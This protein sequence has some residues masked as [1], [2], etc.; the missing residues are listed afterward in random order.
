MNLFIC[1]FGFLRVIPA[2]TRIWFVEE[3][4]P[5]TVQSSNVAFCVLTKP[6]AAQHTVMSCVIDWEIGIRGPEN[7]L[8]GMGAETQE[9]CEQ[10]LQRITVGDS[11]VSSRCSIPIDI[12]KV[13]T[14]EGKIYHAESE[15]T[16][17]E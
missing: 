10:M 14:L 5:Y 2:G 6:F 7:R 12:R 13:K 16:P 17:D 8:F 1:N 3:K 4:M 9:Q 15:V 11:E